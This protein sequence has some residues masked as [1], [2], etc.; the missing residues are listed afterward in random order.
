MGSA[1][2]VKGL[3]AVETAHGDSL[4]QHAADSTPYLVPTHDGPNLLLDR[5]ADHYHLAPGG[6]HEES[7][8]YLRGLW[9][10]E[11]CFGDNDRLVNE[12]Y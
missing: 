9:K 7:G 2:V 4:T 3:E 6:I 12:A 11:P 8:G 10:Q 1:Y 5:S